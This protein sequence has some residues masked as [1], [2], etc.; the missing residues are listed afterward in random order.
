MSTLVDH[1][2]WQLKTLLPAKHRDDI[3][4]ELG[5]D[6]RSAIQDRERAL[7]RALT[8][9]E[10][11]AVLAGFGHPMLIAGRYLPMQQLIGPDVFPLYWYVLQAVL[12]VIAVIGGVLAG[13]AV[14]T[15]SRATQGALQVLTRFF[16]IGIDAA[17][18]VTVAF[19][20]L[21]HEKV[22]FRFL[23]TFDAR[24][25]GTGIWGLRAAPLSPIPRSDTVFELA[26]MAILLLWWA[27]VIVF[28]HEFRAVV[29]SLS[30]ATRPFFFPVLAL[31]VAELARLAV[32]LVRPYRTAP[33]VA[34]RL[35]LNAAWLA[36]AALAFRADG[37]LQGT[38]AA[39]SAADLDSVLSLANT[40]FRVLLFVVGLIS[41]GLIAAD[42]VRLV[43]R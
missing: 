35:L 33:R 13:I 2:L 1:Y 32:D 19:A 29:L 21:D 6:I 24:K 28:P 37:L 18:L 30:P 43:R 26:T 15:D 5:G 3:A 39:G 42:V 22:R 23:E 27:D 8:D 12:I 25:I 20:I 38:P 10:Q 41:A 7:G 40:A 14:L 4:A 31:C 9:D 16:W 17:A 34:L 11:N 36:L